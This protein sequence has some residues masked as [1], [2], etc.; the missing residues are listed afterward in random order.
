MVTSTTECATCHTGFTLS[1]GKCVSNTWTVPALANGARSSSTCKVGQAVFYSCNAGYRL[2]GPA[3]Q[4]CTDGGVRQPAGT[5]ACVA[6]TW[7][8][9]FPSLPHGTVSQPSSAAPGSQATFS[10]D[11]GYTASHNFV[12]TC[13]SNR[14]WSAG[15]PICSPKTCPE[16]APPANGVLR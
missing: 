12:S 2:T 7:C 10:C 4:Y 5:P 16:L 9:A 3:Y 13:Q 14:Y 1:S 8:A 6:T 15:I 11:P